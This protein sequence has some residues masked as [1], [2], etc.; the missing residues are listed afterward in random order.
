MGEGEVI[1][2]TR[3]LSNFFGMVCTARDLDLSFREGS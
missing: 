1:L 3:K 2:E